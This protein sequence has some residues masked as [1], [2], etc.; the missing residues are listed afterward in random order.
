MK[1][2]PPYKEI[3]EYFCSILH[4]AVNFELVFNEPKSQEIS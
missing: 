3:F 2:F 4:T 1:K